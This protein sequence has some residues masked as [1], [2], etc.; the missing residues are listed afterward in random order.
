[1]RYRLG[2]EEIEPG[3]WVAWVLNLPGCT[4][5]A[6]TMDEAVALAPARIVAWHAWLSGDIPP[7]FTVREPVVVEVV[8]TFRAHP[9]AD[10]PDYLVN[11]FWADDRRPLQQTDVDHGLAALHRSRYD[12]LHL[13]ATVPP[14]RWTQPI[15]GETRGSIAGIVRHIAVAEN[16]YCDMFDRGQDRQTLPDDPL[17]LLH[18]VRAH[19]LTTLA[20]LV[21]VDAIT[22]HNGER[23]SARKV[24]RRTLWHERDHTHQL[25]RLLES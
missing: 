10:D 16:W 8:E 2:V 18:A 15:A 6:T 7:A 20:A 12:L 21:E 14:A 24:L 22:Q 1:M 23:W 25:A 9:A 19:T 4:S 13:L 11:A 5:A 3:H 17:A